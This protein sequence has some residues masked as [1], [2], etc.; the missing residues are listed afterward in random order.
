VFHVELRQFPHV[1]RAFN[2]SAE[3]LQERVV[4]HW[5]AGQPVPFEDRRWDPARAK[6]TIYEARELAGDEIG[7]GRGWGTVS[8]EG[9]EVTS[10]V[11]K[12]AR[13]AG[14]SPD[15][16]DELKEE[17][18]AL[19]AQGAPVNMSAVLDAAGDLRSGLSP[20]ERLHVATR[21]VFELLQEG[22]LELSRPR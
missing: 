6:L 20:T 3:G 4:Q 10:R 18:V 7:L 17:V 9:K 5:V 22:R 21:A 19:A 11:L 13:A 16:V 14:P 8:R 12:A 15:A 1:A 2:L